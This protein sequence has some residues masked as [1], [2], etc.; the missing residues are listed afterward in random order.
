MLSISTIAQVI[1]NA[2]RATVAATPFDTGLLMIK[3]SNYL[4]AKRL[5]SYG[6][7]AEAAAGL[8]A[9]GFGDTT[10][11]YQAAQKYFAASPAPTKL[12]VS[13]Y[14][15]SETAVQALDHILDMTA[16]FYGVAYADAIADADWMTLV[17][18]AEGLIKPVVLFAPL[19]GTPA[20]VVA[21]NSLLDRLHAAGARRVVAM[22][23]GAVS[24]AAAW[25]G[26]AMGLQMAHTDSAF[27][28]CYK[29]VGGIQPSELTQSQVDAIEALGGNVYVTR[30][31]TK[32]MLEEGTTPSGY[33]YDEVLYM[34]CIAEDLQNAAVA[35]LADNPDKLPQTD[36]AST[37]F[38]AAFS[39]VLAGY[40]ARGILATSKW[41]G[42]AVG[43]LQPGDYLENGYMLWADSYDHQS[44][45]DRAAHRAVPI[46][47]AL[48]MAGSV[49]SIVIM[50]NVRV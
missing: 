47:V 4:A 16:G 15:S 39:S 29:A 26:T 9:D 48:T 32:R 43:N 50:V 31:Y 21:A 40:T 44:E 42:S 3:D 41:R 2:Q 6:S 7:S 20:N 12:L 19:I 13:C 11:A 33:R 17:T 49:E 36:D 46:H 27:S 14:P 24:D 38:I 37:Q 1:V 23:A 22:Y 25:M 30:G 8:A 34:D 28:L 5:K 10:Q 45:A 18:H 35:L